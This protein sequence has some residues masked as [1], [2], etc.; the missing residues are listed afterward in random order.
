VHVGDMIVDIDFNGSSPTGA[1]PL[2]V[3][4]DATRSRSTDPNNW[5]AAFE[6]DFGD[7]TPHSNAGWVA[8]TYSR[9]GT[10]TA[11]LTVTEGRGQRATVPFI[12]E[13][14][15]RRSPVP[16]VWFS[17]P[18]QFTGSKPLRNFDATLSHG[19]ERDSWI[20][21]FHWD[22]GDGSTSTG[23]W[24]PH[25]Y[26]APGVYRATLTAIDNFGLKQ[27]NAIDIDA[28]SYQTRFKCPA[29]SHARRWRGARLPL[30]CLWAGPSLL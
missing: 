1:V 17:G 20:Q 19:S 27:M 22:F 8:H 7:G 23:G 3:Y 18:D 13:A 4:F 29:C 14:H 10:Y 30:V 24:V 2:T 15:L 16:I 11:S 9:A 25:T 28:P 5:I 26:Q 6:W 12:I 21:A